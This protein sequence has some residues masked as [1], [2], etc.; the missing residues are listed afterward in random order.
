MDNLFELKYELSSDSVTQ[1]NYSTSAATLRLVLSG[2]AMDIYLLTSPSITYSPS[3]SHFMG[4][5]E[6]AARPSASKSKLSV[7]LLFTLVYLPVKYSNA[8]YSA[9]GSIPGITSSLKLSDECCGLV[10]YTARAKFSPLLF[11]TLNTSPVSYKQSS[12][13]YAP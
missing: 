5:M 9:A 4:Y 3:A 7:V 6:Y 10:L 12:V 13:G 11:H 1:K 8:T 2:Y